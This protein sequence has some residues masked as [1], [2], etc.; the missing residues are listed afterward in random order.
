VKEKKGKR[1]LRGR[2][3]GIALEDLDSKLDLIVEKVESTEKSLTDRIDGLETRLT[4]EIRDIHSVVRNHSVLLQGH[5]QK[6]QK[7]DEEIVV[8]KQSSHH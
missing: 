7:H 1:I 5:E 2:M 8:L 6:I 4:Q 3:A